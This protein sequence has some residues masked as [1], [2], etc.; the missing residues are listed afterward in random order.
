MVSQKI[1][2][3]NYRSLWPVCPNTTI[4]T[5]LPKSI[6][7][8]LR[9]STIQS[10]S[11]R[12]RTSSK[13]PTPNLFPHLLEPCLCLKSVASPLYPLPLPLASNVN[14]HRWNWTRMCSTNHRMSLTTLQLPNLEQP[15][16]SPPCQDLSKLRLTQWELAHKFHKGIPIELS[17][18][19]ATEVVASKCLNP[20]Q[21]KHPNS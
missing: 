1:K 14:Y 3:K 9:T 2:N 10:T 20:H 12:Q 15:E 6:N 18:L 21:K 19:T 8:D 4:T 17:W 13:T 7:T 5:T 16:L 11:P